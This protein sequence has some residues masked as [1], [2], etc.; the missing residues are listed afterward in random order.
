[1][2]PG[3]I[4]KKPLKKCYL[5]KCVKVPDQKCTL[6]KFVK[7]SGEKNSTLTK[8]VKGIGKKYE[9]SP[10]ESCGKNCIM[11]KKRI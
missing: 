3:K 6:A 8:Y 4:C 7:N 2:Y 5:E 11:V 9:K 10:P 1:M